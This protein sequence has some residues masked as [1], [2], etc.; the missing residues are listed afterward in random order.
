VDKAVTFVTLWVLLSAAWAAGQ[1]PVGTV[2]NDT[3][4]EVS[5][6]DIRIRSY[7][8]RLRQTIKTG[9]DSIFKVE[10]SLDSRRLA[11]VSPKSLVV[12][13]PK[14]GKEVG[15]I[16]AAFREDGFVIFYDQ[17]KVVGVISRPGNL[18]RSWDVE[19]GRRVK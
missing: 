7:D 13:D 18:V 11:S 19:T 16:K 10:Y 5:G 6:K 15:T 14:T 8:G 9:Q 1:D 3:L 17:N 2:D 12:W 4:V